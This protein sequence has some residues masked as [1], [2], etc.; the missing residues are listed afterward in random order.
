M[1]PILVAFGVFIPTLFCLCRLWKKTAST[2]VCKP[3]WRSW[4]EC[5][6]SLG[7]SIFKENNGLLRSSRYNKGSVCI[8][9]SR[10]LG[11][12]Q[13]WSSSRHLS[14]PEGLEAEPGSLGQWILWPARWRQKGREERETRSKGWLERKAATEQPR[15]KDSRVWRWGLGRHPLEHLQLNTW[16]FFSPLNEET[17]LYGLIFGQHAFGYGTGWAGNLGHLLCQAFWED[18][19]F[20]QVF[21]L[22]M[23]ILASPSH[24]PWCNFNLVSLP[25]PI[26]PNAAI[27]LLT[28]LPIPR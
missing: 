23:T 2:V 1:F 25:H 28:P 14:C 10:T 8:P 26:L 19:T 20:R 13:L 17:H 21:S 22:V 3:G 16:Y 11:L 27:P 5:G 7:F 24:P 18:F 9:L 12:G 4:A 6:V 15:W